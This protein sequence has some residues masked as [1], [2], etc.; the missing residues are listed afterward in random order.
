MSSDT[1][2]PMETVELGFTREPKS[3]KKS[4]YFKQDDS[5]HRFKFENYNSMMTFI[6]CYR[7]N[8][9]SIC[10]ISVDLKTVVECNL[11]FI[12]RVFWV[13]L[14]IILTSQCVQR[15]K[16]KKK[17]FDLIFA[18]HKGYKNFMRHKLR[19]SHRYNIPMFTQ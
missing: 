9:R 8:S 4:T 5:T 13:Y 12:R 7:K 11:E 2:L 10:L 3:A 15:N 6:V 19:L 17:M 18:A 14:S 16:F 1:F